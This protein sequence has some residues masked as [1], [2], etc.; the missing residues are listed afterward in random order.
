MKSLR[1]EI[2]GWKVVEDQG[3]WK[4]F[5]NDKLCG[6]SNSGLAMEMEMVESLL[7]FDGWDIYEQLIVESNTWVHVAMKDMIVDFISLDYPEVCLYILG[8]LEK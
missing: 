1:K 3:T 4:L 2:N 6:H 8:E 5:K 7:P